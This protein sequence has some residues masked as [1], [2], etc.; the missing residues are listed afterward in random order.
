MTQ[1][2]NGWTF[3]MKETEDTISGITSSLNTLQQETGNTN[4]TVS[5]LE[6]AV[7]DLETTAE[8]VR[9]GTWES[10]PCIELGESGSDYSL[11]ITNTRI[12]FRVGSSTP[13]RVTTYGLDTDN[14]SVTGEIRQG[15]WIWVRRTNGHYS[16]MWKEV[17]E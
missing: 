7:A 9:I 1:T 6:Q 16:L 8:Y 13:T 5:A 4:A 17:S 2:E 10:E 14:I 12:L 11:M 15:E 3:S